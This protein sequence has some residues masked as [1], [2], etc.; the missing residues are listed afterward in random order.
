MDWRLIGGAGVIAA[1]ALA[2]WQVFGPLPEYKQRVIDQ[3]IDPT[4]VLFRAERQKGS[5]IIAVHCGQVNAKNRMGGYVGWQDF[6]V[7]PP[8][9]GEDYK[10]S[11]Y[12]AGIVA[13]S[14]ALSPC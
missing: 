8:I 11:I 9:Y 5:G 7:R 4:G 2:G 3:M 6:V 13:T 12:D 14:G 10:V 1:A